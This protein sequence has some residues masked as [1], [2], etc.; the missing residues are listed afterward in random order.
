MCIVSEEELCHN[1]CDIII[2]AIKI[3]MILFSSQQRQ[4]ISNIQGNPTKCQLKIVPCLPSTV[5]WL[6]MIM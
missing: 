5:K 4:K 3:M 2:I 1:L 6:V